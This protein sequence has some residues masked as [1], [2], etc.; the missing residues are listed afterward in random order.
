[1]EGKERKDS[2]EAKR[3]RKMSG[4]CKGKGRTYSSDRREKTKGGAKGGMGKKHIEME[5]A[6]ERDA[7]LHEGLYPPALHKIM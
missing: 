2:K 7:C 4:I 1:M 6:K 3:E 5:W